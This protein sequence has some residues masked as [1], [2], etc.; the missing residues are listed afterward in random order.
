MSLINL[1]RFTSVKQLFRLL[2]VAK[3]IALAGIGRL[4]LM[5][6]ATCSQPEVASNFL[7]PADAP[8]DAK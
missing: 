3:N 1:L 4:T 8:P 2:Q 5:D 7:L 6:N